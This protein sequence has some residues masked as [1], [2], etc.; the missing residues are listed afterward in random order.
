LRFLPGQDFEVV[1][2]EEADQRTAAAVIPG[3]RLDDH[4]LEM[5]E[6]VRV[7]PLVCVQGRGSRAAVSCLRLRAVGAFG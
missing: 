2:T 3:F 7:S 1:A 6:L 5:L 4:D